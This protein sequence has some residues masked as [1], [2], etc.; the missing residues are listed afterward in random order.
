MP[1][2]RLNTVQVHDIRKATE[3]VDSPARDLLPDPGVLAPTLAPSV[4]RHRSIEHAI[5]P[6]DPTDARNSNLSFRVRHA[7]A[8]EHVEF[9]QAE[10]PPPLVTARSRLMTSGESISQRPRRAWVPRPVGAGL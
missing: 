4:P 2:H 6:V 10:R 9:G 3:T 1:A 8:A 5:G 7:R